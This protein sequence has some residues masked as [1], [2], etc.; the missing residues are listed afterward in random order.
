MGR[1]EKI[2]SSA[3]GE[4]ISL[5]GNTLCA[6]AIETCFAKVEPS[7]RTTTQRMSQNDLIV[8]RHNKGYEMEEGRSPSKV[9]VMSS[10]CLM[11]TFDQ[12]QAWELARSPPGL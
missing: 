5:M 3:N 7:L 9:I 1:P 4:V 8:S 12:S 11:R 6:K 2:D 10:K